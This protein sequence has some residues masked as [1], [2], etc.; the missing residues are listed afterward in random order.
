MGT[1]V[2]NRHAVFDFI[3]TLDSLSSLDDILQELTDQLHQF[4]FDHLIFTGLPQGTEDIAPLVRTNLYPVEWWS[5]YTA[6]SYHL[7]D[8]TCQHALKTAQPFFW[9]DVPIEKNV[10]A[11]EQVASEAAQFGLRDG[12]VVP[13][14]SRNHW[15]SVIS[16]ASSVRLHLSKQDEAA[17]NLMAIYASNAIERQLRKSTIPD[18]LTQREIEVLEWFVMGKTAWEVSVILGISDNTVRYHSKRIM[19]KL[20][21]SNLVHAVAKASAHGFISRSQLPNLIGD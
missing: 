8:H 10:K 11:A 9:H 16:M 14:Y 19:N 1:N 21:A 7:V 15:H 4:G 12:Y 2:E 20:Q 5:R 18:K 13:V 3:E 6:N 17:V